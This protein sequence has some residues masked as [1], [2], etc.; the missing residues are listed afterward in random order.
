MSGD[1]LIGQMKA[2]APILS[3]STSDVPIL[4]PFEVIG[5]PMQIRTALGLSV[6][7]IMLAA[8]FLTDSEDWWLSRGRGGG[9]GGEIGSR[10]N[11]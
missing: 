1:R 4:V 7:T 5:T 10:A 3:N 11:E 6:P 9:G 8:A 2:V